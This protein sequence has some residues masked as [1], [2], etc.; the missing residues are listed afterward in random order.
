[1]KLFSRLQT[2]EA[3]KLMGSGEGLVVIEGERMKALQSVLFEMLKDVIKVCEREEIDMTLSGGT[4]LGAIRH[5]GFIPWDDDID[6][7]MTRAGYERFWPIFEAEYADKYWI[8]DAARTEDYAVICPQIRKKGTV[9]KTRDDFNDETD[10]ACIDICI[11]E[12]VPN[13]GILRALQGTL[14]LGF[15]LLASCRRFAQHKEHY[16]S[17]A[18]NDNEVAASVKFKVGIGQ[19]LPFTTY[20]KLNRIWDKINSACSNETTKNMSIPGGRKHYFG[21]TYRREDFFPVS[22]G[23]FEGI[24][25][26]LPKNPDAYMRQ[27]YGDDY[28]TPPPI[29]KREKHVVLEFD[30]GEGRQRL[31]G[32]DSSIL[33]DK[34]MEATS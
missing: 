23:E 18:G 29:E 5:H 34:S 13:S 4:C 15:G 32:S 3:F 27:L 30:L 26:P 16:L 20:G 17:L 31:S 14:S 8:L 1:M 24:R 28:M 7:N 12:N 10:G 19:L 2:M 6:I 11:L 21:E 22:Y 9:V 25:V 33:E